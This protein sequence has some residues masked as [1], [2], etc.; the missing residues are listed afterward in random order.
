V[1]KQSEDVEGTEQFQTVL[2]E[3][4]EFIDGVLT[5]ISVIISGYQLS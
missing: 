2:D 3:E 5:R 1:F 4:A